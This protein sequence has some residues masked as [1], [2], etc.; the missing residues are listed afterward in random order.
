MKR[1][2]VI[3]SAVML[4]STPV[5]AGSNDFVP[6]K[7]A[8]ANARIEAQAFMDSL[9]F[10]TMYTT[11]DVNLRDEASIESLILDTYD[12][13]TEVECAVFNDEWHIVKL[14]QDKYSDKFG[15]IYSQYLSDEKVAV[16]SYSEDDLWWMAHLLAGEMMDES[17]EDQV[18]TGSVC[19]NRVNSDKW[20]G[21][22]LE[23]TITQTKWGKQ[24]ACYWDG[25]FHRE[26]TATNWEVAKYLLEN[27][28]QIP[29]NVVYQSGK[30]LGEVWKHTSAAY[31]CYGNA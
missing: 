21:H 12:I 10:K 17:W 15:Y 23:E 3:V 6:T 18:Y 31:Y 19:L 24:Y 14:P 25:N 16:P 27:G 9:E 4:M 13:N 30:A 2:V 5:F 26:P 28:S 29:Y 22:S 7:V 20:P 8:E 11:T 1:L